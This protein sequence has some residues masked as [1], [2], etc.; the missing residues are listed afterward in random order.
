MYSCTA[1]QLQKENISGRFTIR[2]AMKVDGKKTLRYLQMK[3]MAEV[4]RTTATIAA[5]V[6]ITVHKTVTVTSLSVVTQT[7][8]LSAGMMADAQ[9]RS[10]LMR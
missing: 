4:M 1:K 3:K 5:S 7:V 2:G 10:T 9:Q 8:E 6:S